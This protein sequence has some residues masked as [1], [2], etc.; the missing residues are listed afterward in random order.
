MKLAQCDC[1]GKVV[2]DTEAIQKKWV[3]IRWSEHEGSQKTD[4]KPM[5]GKYDVCTECRGKFFPIFT[6]RIN[7][8]DRKTATT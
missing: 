8:R 1:C 2:D 6:F 7:E 5:I 4:V 3:H